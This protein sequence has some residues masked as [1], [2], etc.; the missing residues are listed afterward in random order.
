MST[1]INSTN[2]SSDKNPIAS[3]P[4]PSG[5]HNSDVKDEGSPSSIEAPSPFPDLVTADLSPIPVVGSNNMPTLFMAQDSNKNSG[6]C[7]QFLLS[8]NPFLKT[9]FFTFHI[10]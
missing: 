7:T 8:W 3:P 4:T 2:V 6:M 5:I 9:I 10:Y 1:S